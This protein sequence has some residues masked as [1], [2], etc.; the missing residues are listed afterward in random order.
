MVREKGLE[1][2][3]TNDTRL[4]PPACSAA[5][6]RPIMDISLAQGGPWSPG[7]HVPRGV[8]ILPREVSFAA[9]DYQNGL[10]A[11]LA[12]DRSAPRTQRGHPITQAALSARLDQ[13]PQRCWLVTPSPRRRDAP[14]AH[15]ARAERARGVRVGLGTS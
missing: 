7:R 3:L 6:E 8:A 2:G 14:Y 4:A 9:P 15:E 1:L 5:S 10:P 11:L 12:R 13:V